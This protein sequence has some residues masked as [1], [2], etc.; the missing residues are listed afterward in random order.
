MGPPQPARFGAYVVV[1]NKSIFLAA[2]GKKICI[3][4]GVVELP[5]ELTSHLHHVSYFK[6]RP[7]TH[8]PAPPRPPGKGEERKET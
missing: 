2:T 3:L 5:S 7:A 8:V 1:L 4:G 6:I